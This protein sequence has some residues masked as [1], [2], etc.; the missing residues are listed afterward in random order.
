LTILLAFES[1]GRAVGPHRAITVPTFH[2]LVKLNQHPFEGLL[3]DCELLWCL[4]SP[5]VIGGSH[6]SMSNH[7]CSGG[8]IGG[9]A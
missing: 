9:A 3:R 6:I 8:T 1:N 2:L 4:K 7:E 5:D